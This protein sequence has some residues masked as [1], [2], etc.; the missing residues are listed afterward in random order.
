VTFVV[1]R[2]AGAGQSEAVRLC[3]APAQ[4]VTASSWT[5]RHQAA[6]AQRD[7]GTGTTWGP[8]GTKT[9]TFRVPAG[10]WYGN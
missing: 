9:A 7:M 2:E 1:E 6:Q 4:S 3:V 8:N 5:R 10:L